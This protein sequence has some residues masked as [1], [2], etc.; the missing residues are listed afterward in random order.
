MQEFSRLLVHPVVAELVFQTALEKF[1]D[2]MAV[3]EFV[4][5]IIAEQD[6]VIQQD[7]VLPELFVE[8]ETLEEQ[9]N[10][11]TAQVTEHA[12]QHVALLAHL[13][14]VVEGAFR[15]LLPI[16]LLMKEV[17]QMLMTV[18]DQIME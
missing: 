15:D 10:V 11:I 13:T 16:I 17:E 6:H 4:L 8:M 1:V 12:L 9:S 7:N 18:L 5:L 14:I 2:L 3:E